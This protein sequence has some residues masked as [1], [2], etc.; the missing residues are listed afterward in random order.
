MDFKYKETITIKGN[1][2][3]LTGLHI[4]GNKDIFKIGGVDCPVIKDKDEWPYIPGSSLKGKLR[5]LL[6]RKYGIKDIAKYNGENEN[7]TKIA[8]LFGPHNS[9]DRE[10]PI[11]A[12]FRDAFL[13]EEDKKSC[14]INNRRPD[15][16]KLYEYKTENTIDRIK[17]TAANPR[18]I[19][20]VVPNLRFL[21]EIVFHKYDNDKYDSRS[22][23]EL[24]KE[25]FE[26]LSNDYLGGSG[27]RGYGRV[28]VSEIIRDIEKKL[29]EST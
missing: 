11:I 3:I 6:E 2:K 29:E 17:G 28:D 21:V 19:E 4:G 26:L 9:K 20:R 13:V 23:L 7:E 22:M 5:S 24:L 8:V 14:M 1:L 10:T 15:I 12:V 18:T 25:A 16:E 27:T